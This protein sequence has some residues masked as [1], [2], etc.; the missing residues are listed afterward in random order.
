MNWPSV[1]TVHECSKAVLVLSFAHAIFILV[2]SMEQSR[3][4][5]PLQSFFSRTRYATVA[6][7]ISLLR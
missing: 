2:I 5:Y 3:V 7:Q 1:V 6:Q 4:G